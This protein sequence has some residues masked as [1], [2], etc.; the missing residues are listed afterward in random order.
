MLAA[1]EGARIIAGGQ[2]LV[3]MMAMRLARP[4][5]LVDISRIPGLNHIRKDGGSLAIGAATRQAEAERDPLVREHVPLLARALGFVG[6]A[7]TRARG[8]IGGSLANADPAAEI[9]LVAV[10]LGATLVWRQDGTDHERPA[11]GFFVGPMATNLPE[12]ACLS[13]VRFPL[14]AGSRI[15]TGF[16]EV[17]ARKSDFAYAMAAAQVSL[18]R[19][20]RCERAAV[21]V[22]A[23]TPRPVRL[24]AVEAALQGRQDGEGLRETVEAA[25]A[26]LEI[27]EDPYASVAYRKRAAA[28]LA[29]RAI[30]EAFGDAAG[31]P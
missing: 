23:A 17:N 20:G 31:R 26:R 30:A 6:H 7:P 1:D 14:W 21:G 18:G 29:L 11:D 15:G 19:D 13:A 12:T 24:A 25:V 3:P 22:G 28:T 4:S 5:R 2:T 10:A 16:Q 9:S 27:V 8:T